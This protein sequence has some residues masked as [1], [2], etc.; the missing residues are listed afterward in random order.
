MAGD[1]I[2]QVTMWTSSTEY[3]RVNAHSREQSKGN[4]RKHDRIHDLGASSYVHQDY[5]YPIV[6][7]YVTTVTLTHVTSMQLAA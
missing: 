5:S 6:G 4:Q 1:C 3:T 2:T 7:D